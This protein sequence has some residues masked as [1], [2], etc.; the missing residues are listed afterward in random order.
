[1]FSIVKSRVNRVAFKFSFLKKPY[2]LQAFTNY[3]QGIGAKYGQTIKL[4]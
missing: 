4:K 3:R 1:M 2:T